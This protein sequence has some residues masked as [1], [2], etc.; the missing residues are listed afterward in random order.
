MSQ[1]GYTSCLCRD[2]M[3]IAVSN[4]IEAP[5]MCAECH[6][7]GCEPDQECSVV[8]DSWQCFATNCERAGTYHDV[9]EGCPD[10]PG[11]DR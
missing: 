7:A 2:C 6:K 8:R 5:E 9:E 4:D 3:E 11:G 10:W 1:S